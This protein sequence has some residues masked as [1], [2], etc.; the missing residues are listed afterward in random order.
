MI[1]SYTAPEISAVSRISTWATKQSQ[2]VRHTP[3]PAMT[4]S[5]AADHWV[6]DGDYGRLRTL[7]DLNDLLDYLGKKV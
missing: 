6:S 2:S 4:A 3:L 5:L 1:R 7:N